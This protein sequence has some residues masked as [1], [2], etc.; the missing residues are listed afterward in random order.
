MV[1][2]DSLVKRYGKV[3]AVD[4]ISFEVG[5]G[6]VFGFLGPNGAGKTTTLRMITG[7]S[8]PTSGTAMVDG[9]DVSRYPTRVHR[10]IGV[11]FEQPNL[12]ERL[13][14]EENMR[15][16]GR[17]YGVGKA[18]VSE[19]LERLELGDAAR[20]PVQKYSKGMQQKILIGRAL[21]H[22]PKVLFLDEPTSG[23]DPSAAAIIRGMVKELNAAGTTVILTTHY[24]EEADELCG[25][26]AF[27]A[28][29]KIAA[30]DEP[31]T[32]KLQYGKRQ[33]RVELNDETPN[34]AGAGELPHGSSGSVEIPMDSPDV[35]ARLKELVDSGRVKTIHTQEATLADVF[36][37]L[38]GRELR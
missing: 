22:Q 28:A 17:L 10:R 9:I 20:R 6:E 30:I 34:G 31:Q 12:Y 18:R 21:L 13:T 7:L 15:F 27:I 23:L 3:S 19:V 25:R 24:M 16:F 8:R 33:I 11:V 5:E 4:G 2:V 26:V 29:G 1:R 14:G 35:G 32:L 38:T 36:I 37:R